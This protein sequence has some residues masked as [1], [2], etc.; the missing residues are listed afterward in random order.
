M[1]N[2]WDEAH[3]SIAEDLAKDIHFETF[4]LNEKEDLHVI[5]VCNAPRGTGVRHLICD[6]LLHRFPE[7]MFVGCYGEI[8]SNTREWYLAS[9][10]HYSRHSPRLDLRTLP[11]RKKTVI[12]R[13]EA[14]FI[15]TEKIN[16]D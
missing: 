11:L 15:Y 9:S 16:G 4:L 2:S 12:S 10:R 1:F 13:D 6:L 3:D 14:C 8:E 5:P 7:V